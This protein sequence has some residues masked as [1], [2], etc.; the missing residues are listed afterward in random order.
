MISTTRR[1]SRGLRWTRRVA[2][3]AAGFALAASSQI[4]SADEGGVSFWLPGQFGSLA[5]VPLQPGLS[6]TEIYYHWQGSAGADV[7][8]AREVTI[9]QFNPALNVNLSGHLQ[10][11]ADLMLNNATYA[12]GT[13]VLGGQATVGLT[14]I[15]GRTDT[16][17][18]ATLSGTLGPI[19]FMRTDSL[20][21]AATGFGDL[22]PMATLR[23]NKG[24]DNYMVYVTGDVPVGM[25][26]SSSIAN[27]GIGHGAID[28]GAGYTY[29]NP[30]T[31]HE[32]SA[33]T[34]FTY[35]FINPAT[36]YQNG[37]DWHLDW[38]VSQFLTKQ[39]MIGT[40]GYVYQQVTGDSGPG[41]RIGA[42]ESRV[43]GIG[44]QIGFLFPVA[45]PVGIMQGYLNLK[46]YA[47]FDRQNRPAGLDTWLTFSISP[48][49]QTSAQPTLVRKY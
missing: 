30:Q 45:T 39:M 27:L 1:L 24:V 25:Y 14:S 18:N 46:G 12:F 3:G 7:S 8:A 5:A 2:V 34:G 33:V 44:P 10:A 36:Q 48:A 17:L 37:I 9:G 38:A 15:F 6:V 19:P 16:S 21:D 13:P 43:I 47:E 4:A 11:L 40:V 31:G 28:S 41:D 20:F 23:W 26:N 42:F 35:N 32:F 22:Y 29:F 49:P